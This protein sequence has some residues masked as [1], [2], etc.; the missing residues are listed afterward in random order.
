[1]DPLDI[2]RILELQG[3][4]HAAMA[5]GDVAT[6]EPLLDEALI[7]THSAGDSDSK[8]SYLR[9][10]REGQMRYQQVQAI[11]QSVLR[12]GD[13]AACVVG[14]MLLTGTLHGEEKRLDNRFLAVWVQRGS[15]WK[16]LAFQPTPMAR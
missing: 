1:M 2:A 6:L 16:L 8:E 10:V 7:Y 5:A 3:R 15:D 4:R 11:E 12:A 14:R 9:K 13:T